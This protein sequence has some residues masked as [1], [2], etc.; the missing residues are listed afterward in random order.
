GRQREEIPRKPPPL[1]PET[2]LP[3]PSL[4]LRRTGRRPPG[5]PPPPPYSPQGRLPLPPEF[6]PPARQTAETGV[7]GM[8]S[9]ILHHTRTCC[10]PS[11]LTV[12]HIPAVLPSAP[13]SFRLL[14]PQAPSGSGIPSL[15]RQCAHRPVSRS[16]DPPQSLPHTRSLP[17]IPPASPESGR[18]P[19]GQVCASRPPAAPGR[20]RK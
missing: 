16:P 4:P 14:R 5:C 1:L 18:S 13:G 6:P 19:P 7:P 12:P 8:F 11:F 3:Y 2:F 9:G 10:V 15:Q 17:P 20:S